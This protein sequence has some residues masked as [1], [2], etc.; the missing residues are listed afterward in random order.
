MP[1]EQIEQRNYPEKICI[2]LFAADGRQ[3][4]RYAY[5]RLSIPTRRA[6][7]TRKQTRSKEKAKAWYL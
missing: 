2:L 6:I 3:D 7:I 4:V 5:H 1:L